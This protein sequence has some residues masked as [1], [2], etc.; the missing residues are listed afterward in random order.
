MKRGS[1]M[2]ATWCITLWILSGMI[3][4]AAYRSPVE[5]AVVGKYLVPA[6]HDTGTSS[7][8]GGPRSI[9]GGSCACCSLAGA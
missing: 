1:R 4:D 8:T 5:V 9:R 7:E 3:A 6:H 2:R